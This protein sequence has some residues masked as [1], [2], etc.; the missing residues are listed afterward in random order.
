MSWNLPNILTWARI[1]MIPILGLM[2]LLPHPWSNVVAAAIFGVAAVTDWFD[3]YLARRWNQ[4]SAFGAFLDPVADKLIVAVA[5]IA[6]LTANASAALAIPIAVI[7]GREIA[8]SALRE[9]MAEL[10]LRA[11]VAVGAIGKFKTTA[12]MVA[13]LLL[14]FSHDVYG[15]SAFTVGFWLL[16]VAAALTIYSM[17]LYLMA[18]WRA[19]GEGGTG[20]G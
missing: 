13:I 1:V 20:R 16:Y 8:V 14:L 18:A 19:V 5:L 6:V 9:W 17:S 2:F 10:G 11:S 7:I 3:G 15:V 4:T 12:Q